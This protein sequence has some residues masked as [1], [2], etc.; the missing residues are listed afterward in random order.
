MKWAK[1]ILAVLAVLV[2]IALAAPFF[3]SI[4]DYIPRIEK[5]LS[6]RLNEPVS[7]AKIRFSVFPVPHLVV[8][9]ISLGK[10]GDLKVGKV[11]V[12]PELG[13]L[14]SATKVVRSI[15]IDSLV[16]TQKA[17]EK[18]PLG[19]KPGEPAAVRVGSIR[20]D[21]ALVKLDRAQFG[22]FDAR[23]KL[24]EKGEPI[25]ITMVTKDGKL[26]ARAVPDKQPGSFSVSVNA[27]AWTPPAGPAIVF[28]EL[29][30]QGVVTPKDAR[31]HQVVARLYG[32]TAKG[33]LTAAWQKGIQVKG[34]LDV[35]D[36]ETKDLVPILSPGTKVSGKLSAKPVF[37]A[38]APEP[39]K[40]AES[41]HLETPFSVKNGVLYGVDIQKAATKLLGQGGT[42]GETRFEHLSGHLVMDRASY[43]F[44]QLNIASGMLAADG[45]VTIS[46][47]Q[48]LS[49]RVNAKVNA[50]G[51]A[52]SIPL[53]VAGTVHS[54]SLMPT[55]ATITGA[56]IG[57][58]ILPG[59]GTGVGAK[60]GQM[61]EGLFGKKEPAKK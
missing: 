57:T 17:F 55:G 16:M 38:S 2:A 36:V 29:D 47:K 58:A 44:S 26:K 59:I 41:L 46:P 21:D 30:L 39:A 11:T 24:D 3:I 33:A 48:E 34:N 32:G 14:F 10:T 9:G 54:P 40:I 52:A 31:F 56:A 42:G 50:L 20:L 37:S 27:K 35:A 4:D 60:A 23:M 45:A 22:P 25:E 28:N 53:N 8:N 43:K 49:G 18:I 61:I 1:G 19:S 6:A 7:I 5:E 12:T 15:E 13:S 51:G